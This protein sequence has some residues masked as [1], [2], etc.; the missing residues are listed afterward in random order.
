MVEREDEKPDWVFAVTTKKQQSEWV[1]RSRVPP[2]PKD[3]IDHSK[4]SK[5][6][7]DCRPG[8]MGADDPDKKALDPDT[9][10]RFPWWRCKG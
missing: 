8:F 6:A 2:I 1:L 10:T 9:L 3:I 7:Q 5:D 4:E